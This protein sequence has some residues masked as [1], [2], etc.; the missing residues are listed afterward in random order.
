MIKKVSILCSSIILCAQSYSAHATDS[1]II[2]DVGSS[3]SKVYF[4][5]EDRLDCDKA[6]TTKRGLHHYKKINALKRNDSG[7]WKETTSQHIRHLIKKSLRLYKKKNRGFRGLK[8]FYAYASAGIRS[9]IDISQEPKLFEKDINKFLNDLFVQQLYIINQKRLAN[10][11]RSIDIPVE[12]DTLTGTEEAAY[13]LLGLNY[14]KEKSEFEDINDMDGFSMQHATLVLDE[15]ERGPYSIDLDYKG[16][17]YK[18]EG[19]SYFLGVDQSW[20]A[21]VGQDADH[22][23]VIG[24]NAKENKEDSLDQCIQAVKSYVA[25]QQVQE[26]TPSERE[27]ILMG[28]GYKHPL[29]SLGLHGGQQTVEDFMKV[30]ESTALDVCSMSKADY[31]ATYMSSPQ[32]QQQAES[33]FDR[34]HKA[35]CFDLVH[36]KVILEQLNLPQSQILN[37]NF[38]QDISWIKGKLMMITDQNRL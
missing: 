16:E 12:F 5:Y 36:Y 22:P 8:G 18:I 37:L 33:N 20:N 9:I 11:R 32:N 25:Q 26:V 6:L 14:G 3:S 27:L 30:L 23:C 35:Y 17:V 31:I 19:N 13:T 2:V 7:S 4:C 34:Y 21:V 10:G 38:S 24:I 1:Y 29:K 28:N 15:A